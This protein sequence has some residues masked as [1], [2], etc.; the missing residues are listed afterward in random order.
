MLNIRIF[1]ENR[2]NIRDTKYLVNLDHYDELNPVQVETYS[3]FYSKTQVFKM[4][5]VYKDLLQGNTNFCYL[6]S[7]YCINFP[8]I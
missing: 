8:N 3:F 7:N 4:D 6:W 5:R 1:S 2:E